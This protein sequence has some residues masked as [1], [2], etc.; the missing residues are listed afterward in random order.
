MP[1]VPLSWRFSIHVYYFLPG[2]R[3]KDDGQS[4]NSNLYLL[5][6]KIQILSSKLAKTYDLINNIIP[7]GPIYIYIYIS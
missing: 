4:V 5:I 1:E 2:S 3:L 6:F 7:N